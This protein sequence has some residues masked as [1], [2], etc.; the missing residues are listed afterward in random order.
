[1][2]IVYVTIKGRV[3]R[4]AIK[5]F[6]SKGFYWRSV[7]WDHKKNVTVISCRSK[8]MAKRIAW[9]FSWKRK[10]IRTVEVDLLVVEQRIRN[11]NSGTG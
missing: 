8:L 7:R 9:Y 6:F 10:T 4:R 5:R 2:I 1:M 11:Y 3:G